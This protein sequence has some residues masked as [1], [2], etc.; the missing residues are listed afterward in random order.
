MLYHLRDAEVGFLNR[1]LQLWL[2]EALKLCVE[3]VLC[4]W[5]VLFG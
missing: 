3:E 4:M 1:I 2:R 5:R